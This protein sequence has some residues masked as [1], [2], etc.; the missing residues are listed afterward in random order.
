M[1]RH[2]SRKIHILLIITA[3]LLLVIASTFVI[4]PV[5][6]SQAKIRHTTTPA[7]GCGKRPPITPGN[8]AN[9]T[10]VSGGLKRKYRLHV[11]LDYHTFVKHTLV[12]N[13]HGHG[14][15]ALTQE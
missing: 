12:L 15:N 11:P 2:I 1:H 6:H 3:V 4:N 14:S 10:I 5:P 9:E 7:S 8:S 13:F